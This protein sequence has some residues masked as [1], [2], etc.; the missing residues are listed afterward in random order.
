MNLI[1][2]SPTKISFKKYCL[3]R[4]DYLH[5]HV[6][7]NKTIAKVNTNFE[8]A[9]ISTKKI[10]EKGEKTYFFLKKRVKRFADTKISATFAS[11]LRNKAIN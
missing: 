7:R 6:I 5:C 9:S 10:E 4:S 3:I 11:Q 1:A 8:I 2:I